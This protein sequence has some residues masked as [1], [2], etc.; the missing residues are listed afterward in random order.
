MASKHFGGVLLGPVLDTW[1]RYT[2]FYRQFPPRSNHGLA[3]LDRLVAV[4]PGQNWAYLRIPKAAN[5]AVTVTLESMLLRQT[6]HPLSSRQARRAFARPS[7]LGRKEATQLGENGFLFTVV[8]NPYHRILS[9]Y[10]DK[11][12]EGRR[13]PRHYR[14]RYGAALN[15]YDKA[16]AMSFSGFCRWLEAG[17]WAANVHWLP[18]THIIALLGEQRLNAIAH[19]EQLDDEL[20]AIIAQLT[21]T[22]AKIQ[23]ERYTGPIS[24]HAAE[25][26]AAYYDTETTDIIRRIYKED[27]Q[28]LSY[29]DRLPDPRD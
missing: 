3:T 24:T 11:F 23:I 28:A 16:G 9:A 8:R 17:G 14:S 29:Q 15:R 7:L 10:L 19:V 25:R 1:C 20:A 27:F 4:A 5:S 13:S 2:P 18:Q 26:C 22:P 12:C 21:N 6:G